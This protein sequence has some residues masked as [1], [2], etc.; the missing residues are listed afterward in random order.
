MHSC[1]NSSLAPRREC[2]YP[3]LICLAAVCLESESGVEVPPRN[4]VKVCIVR[5]QGAK[6]T[7]TGLVEDQDQRR[8]APCERCAS[9]STDVPTFL[10]P[11]QH[12][13][14]LQSV[15]NRYLRRIITDSR[16]LLKI[17]ELLVW[18][19]HLD[20]RSVGISVDRRSRS[21]P[22]CSLLTTGDMYLRRVGKRTFWG[23]PLKLDSSWENAGFVVR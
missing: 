22:S 6:I 23:R 15:K 9:A 4:E 17:Q 2:S 21:L 14:E 20:Q 16:Q 18:T 7:V 19:R 3:G 12:V 11:Y 1:W 13:T 5:R 10:P 8:S